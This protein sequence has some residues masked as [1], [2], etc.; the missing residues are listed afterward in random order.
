MIKWLI[1]TGLASVQKGYL[2]FSISSPTPVFPV[3]VHQL[4]ERLYLI[5]VAQI[6]L[7]HAKNIWVYTYSLIFHSEPE[8]TFLEK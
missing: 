4:I 6:M 1:L 5:G 8:Q 7:K 3:L 2:G